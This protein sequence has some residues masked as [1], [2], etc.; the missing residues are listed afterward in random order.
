MSRSLMTKQ[1]GGL[2]EFGAAKLA[3]KALAVYSQMLSQPG[4]V[5]KDLVTFRAGK[6]AK[7]SLLQG[8]LVAGQNMANQ[9][10]FFGKDDG[11]VVTSE[12]VAHPK[13]IV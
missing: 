4:L 11:A 13:V 5:G 3:L 9:A 8:V 6:L 10:E 7:F 1:P 2:G 12:G